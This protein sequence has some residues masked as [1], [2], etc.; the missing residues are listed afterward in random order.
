MAALRL[1]PGEEKH[2]SGPVTTYK[3]KKLEVPSHW[4]RRQSWLSANLMDEQRGTHCG[5]VASSVTKLS[6]AFEEI[7]RRGAPLK[8]TTRRFERPMKFAMTLDNTRARVHRE[9]PIV[10]YQ[11]ADPE[12]EENDALR[13]IVRDAIKPHVIV[14]ITGTKQPGSVLR[15]PASARDYLNSMYGDRV[16][17]MFYV[18]DFSASRITRFTPGNAKSEAR[19]RSMAWALT[20]IFGAILEHAVRNNGRNHGNPIS[21]YVHCAQGIERSRFAMLLFYA[22]AHMNKVFANAPCARDGGGVVALSKSAIE[23]QDALEKWALSE[24]S[25]E[26]MRSIRRWLNMDRPSIYAALVYSLSI[27]FANVVAPK[28]ILESLALG[29]I[30]ADAGLRARFSAVLMSQLALVADGEMHYHHDL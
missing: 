9:V 10:F 14:R 19:V 29:E 7:D 16:Q 15:N 2:V 5:V 27:V 26:E 17:R 11:G 18:P 30:P 28:K 23:I 21:V 25:D 4:V 12:L 22:M 8:R 6:Y 13:T 20:D 3:V 1:L 24:R